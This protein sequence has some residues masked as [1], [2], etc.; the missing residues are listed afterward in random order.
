VLTAYESQRRLTVNFLAGARK[1]RISY[2]PR[3]LV[4]A[5]IDLDAASKVYVITVIGLFVSVSDSATVQKTNSSAHSYS[6]FLLSY[7][8]LDRVVSMRAMGSLAYLLI[9]LTAVGVL[10]GRCLSWLSMFVANSAA[11]SR[12]SLCSYSGQRWSDLGS[13]GRFDTSRMCTHGHGRPDWQS[14]QGMC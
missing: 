11:G 3:G 12:Q 8:S 5:W 6:S 2:S 13:Y 1:K 9:T 7:S 14:L 4:E 10:N